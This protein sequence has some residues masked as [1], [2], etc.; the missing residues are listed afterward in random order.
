MLRHATDCH[1]CPDSAVAYQV[2]PMFWT[3]TPPG[4]P[5]Q[6]ARPVDDGLG[7]YEERPR[8]W[9]PHQPDHAPLAVSTRSTRLATRSW[10]CSGVARSRFSDIESRISPT[11]AGLWLATAHR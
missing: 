2:S 6:R 3:Q 9:R 1:A 11:A 7:G 5:E 8:R 10:T 4:A